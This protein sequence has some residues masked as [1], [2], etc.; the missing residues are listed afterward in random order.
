[1]LRSTSGTSP[2]YETLVVTA[3]GGD[4]TVKT[5]AVT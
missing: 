4:T 3:H 5:V 2:L 1:V